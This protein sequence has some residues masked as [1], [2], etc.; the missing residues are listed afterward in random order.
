MNIGVKAE[1][2]ASKASGVTNLECFQ[3]YLVTSLD[4]QYFGNVKE[5]CFVQVPRCGPMAGFEHC[6]VLERL[7]LPECRLERIEGLHA[8]RR[9]RVLGLGGNK[10]KKIEGLDRLTALEELW[11]DDNKISLL[12]GLDNLCSLRLLSIARNQIERVGTALDHLDEVSP[13][14]PPPPQPPPHPSLTTPSPL[15]LPLSHHLSVGRLEHG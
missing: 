7:W 14:T 6:P 9:L 3:T 13:P 5:I 12:E 11:L 2:L 8:N 1:N 10:I 15:S 4:V